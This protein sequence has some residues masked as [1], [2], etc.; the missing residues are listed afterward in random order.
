[1]DGVLIDSERAV[2]RAWEIVGARYGLKN[3]I[4]TANRCK[5]CNRETNRRIF[6]EAYGQDFPYEARSAESKEIFVKM[7]ANGE[8]TLKDGVEETLVSLKNKGIKIALA[9]STSEEIALP[10]LESYGILHFFDVKVCG[11]RVKKSKPDPEIFLLAAE[12]LGFSV[13]R[14]MV[15]EDSYKGVLAGKNASMFTVMVPDTL[16]PNELMQE[17]AD[18][19]IDSLPLLMNE[20]FE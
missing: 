10:E 5:G 9:T 1:M 20:M 16:P 2:N 4:D 3:V 11:N 7:M 6:K 13:D 12:K 14:V 18:I 19:I 8:I 17:K 15:V